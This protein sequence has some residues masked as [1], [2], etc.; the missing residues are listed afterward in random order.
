MPHERIAPRMESEALCLTAREAAFVA[1]YTA[2]RNATKSAA[3]AGYS[4]KTAHVMGSKLLRKPRV[5]EAIRA[6]LERITKKFEISA[7]RTLQEMAAIGYSDIRH[8]R[9]D[10]EG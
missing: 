3:T 1:A 2:T 4:A 9:F 7:E 5:S 10:A 6:A 8:Y